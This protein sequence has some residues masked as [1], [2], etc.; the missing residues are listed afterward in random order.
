MEYVG[1]RRECYW[2]KR[3]VFHWDVQVGVGSVFRTSVHICC[4]LHILEEMYLVILDCSETDNIELDF[5]GI[6]LAYWNE[7][8]Y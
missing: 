8:Y 2:I 4:E 5:F 6:A 7:G 1:K 3:I